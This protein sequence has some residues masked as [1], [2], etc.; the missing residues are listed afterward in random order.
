MPFFANGDASTAQGCP[1]IG[2]ATLGIQIWI[3]NRNAVPAREE[4]VALPGMAKEENDWGDA[5]YFYR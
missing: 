1:T 2:M 3:S 4:G 5:G